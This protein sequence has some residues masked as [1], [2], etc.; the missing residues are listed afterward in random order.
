MEM[1]THSKTFIHVLSLVQNYRF[2]SQ[3]RP[4]VSFTDFLNNLLYRD[5]LNSNCI[6]SIQLHLQ[7]FVNIKK[8]NQRNGKFTIL[9][10]NNFTFPQLR[11][12]IAPFLY[13]FNSLS[14]LQSLAVKVPWIIF[15]FDIIL[16]L[17]GMRIHRGTSCQITS[18]KGSQNHRLCKSAGAAWAIWSYPRLLPAQFHITSLPWGSLAWP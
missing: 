8:K 17:E 1:E 3:K 6:M 2:Y 10:G 13:Q 4:M 12:C 7:Y 16:K 11:F 5:C 18:T 15:C 9:L 14:V